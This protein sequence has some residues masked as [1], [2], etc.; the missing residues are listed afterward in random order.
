MTFNEHSNLKDAHA[1]LSPSKYHW[2]NYDIDKLRD[3]FLKHVAAQKGTELH[4]FA[5][6]AIQLRIKL[7]KVEKTLNLY[8]NDAIKYQMTAEQCLYYSENCFGTAD[9]IS[10]D[11][12]LLR[13]HDLKTGESSSSMNQ[14]LIYAAIFCL[15]YDIDP[16]EITVELRIYQNNMVLVHNPRFEEI[17]TIMSTIIK[18]DSEIRNMKKG[19]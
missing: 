15:E 18:F 13:I 7:P 16:E 11:G 4:A 10:F 6:K 2:I 1:F 19:E 14:L 17:E 8:V 3:S 12:K 9:A 5:A